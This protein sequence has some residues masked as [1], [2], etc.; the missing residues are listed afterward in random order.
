MGVLQNTNLPCLPYF[1]IFLRDL[2]FVD[3]SLDNTLENGFVNFH[4][5]KRMTSIAQSIIHYQATPFSMTVKGHLY[6][7]L[8]N[9]AP[10]REDT[11]YDKSKNV[12]L[13]RNSGTSKRTYYSIDLFVRNYRVHVN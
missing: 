6:N 7:Y 8:K 3:D 9:V 2:T 10:L 5:M 4:K 13:H 1:G 12:N 11:L